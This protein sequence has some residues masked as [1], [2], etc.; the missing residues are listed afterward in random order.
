MKS[1]LFSALIFALTF[2]GLILVEYENPTRVALEAMQVSTIPLSSG[3]P[4]TSSI[5][6]GD[7][8]RVCRIGDTQY[9]IQLPGGAM[10]LR[11]ELR[12]NVDADFYIR[13]NQP[14][15]RQDGAIIADF[16]AM[17][18]GLDESLNLPLIG[19]PPLEEGTYFIAIGNCSIS[20]Q[21]DFTL[22]ATI[23]TPSSEETV[24][25]T[26]NA[27]EVGSIPASTSG[28][29]LGQT[30]YIFPAIVR[31]PCGSI[32][33]Y[34][35]DLR[36]DQNVDLYIRFNQR[37]AMEDG[38]I[39]ADF[40]AQS[41]SMTEFIIP[42]PVAQEGVYYIAVANCSSEKAN[43]TIVARSFP[44]EPPI[45]T[46]DLERSPSGSFSLVIL[47][48]CIK[49]GA[50]ITVGGVTPKKVKFKLPDPT[51]TFFAKVIAKGKVCRGLP[52]AI[53]IR[54]PGESPAIAF[55]CNEVCRD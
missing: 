54:N 50:S 15:V 20:E 22:V 42:D 5:P 2:A 51:G 48:H 26:L 1:L 43:F 10:K 14:V 11:V 21:A 16:K 13:R 3:F 37:V 18:I 32:P 52:G 28:C 27:P 7:P 38:R 31:P 33:L 41:D 40:S 35:V 24:A 25:L 45:P 36:G 12:A 6:H 55:Q 8:F 49:R 29:L 39:I 19:F 4:Q 23:L 30:Q 46:C 34:A 44:Y 53:I 47:S 17:T 9:T